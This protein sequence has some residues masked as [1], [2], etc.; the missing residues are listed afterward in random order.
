MWCDFSDI[1]S[2]AQCL[3]GMFDFLCTDKLRLHHIRFLLVILTR[4]SLLHIGLNRKASQLNWKLN[5]S[6]EGVNSQTGN[7]QYQLSFMLQI[8]RLPLTYFQGLFSLTF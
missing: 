6:N 5:I 2:F 8:S 3:R 7:K 4:L 1:S